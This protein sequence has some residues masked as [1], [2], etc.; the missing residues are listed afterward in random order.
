MSSLFQ[1][2][3]DAYRRWSED[4]G[5]LLSAGVAYY[6]AL[7]LFP[8]LLILI[9]AL[10]LFF[11]GTDA[12]QQA[13]SHVIQAVSDQLSPNLADQLREV[14]EQVRG[15][16]LVGGPIGIITLL[17]AAMAMFS[18]FDH[19]FDW[20][21]NIEPKSNRGLWHSVLTV[22]RTRLKALLMLLALGALVLAV[23]VAGVV[24]TTVQETSSEWIPWSPNV[25]WLV[26]FAA[27]LSMNILA[28]TLIYRWIPKV[29]V[30]WTHALA[31][32]SFAA[33]AWEIGRQILASYVIGQ[34]YDNAYGLLGTFLAIMLWAYY[35]VSV[36]FF[37]AEFIQA[38]RARDDERLTNSPVEG[39]RVAP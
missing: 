23:F 6:I 25:G 16:A 35:A 21:W 12:G 14:F 39:E 9:A 31:G 3:S 4:G 11:Q 10:G 22:L 2:L 28:F 24:V 27:T 38:I 33:I 20:I 13:E 1:L 18:Q 8:M 26:D 37:S 7:S 36:L 15:K 29:N 17:I 30:A 34:R 32:G 5:P 19:A